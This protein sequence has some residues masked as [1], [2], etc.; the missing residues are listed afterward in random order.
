MEDW[1]ESVGQNCGF[2]E[3]PFQRFVVSQDG[4]LIESLSKLQILSGLVYL[5]D[6][7]IIHRGQWKRTMELY[8]IG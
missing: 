1:R 8:S 6:H 7:K 5:H 4:Q 3:F 2:S